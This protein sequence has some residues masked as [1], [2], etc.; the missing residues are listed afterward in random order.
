MAAMMS[1]KGSRPLM[2]YASGTSYRLSYRHAS[3]MMSENYMNSVRVKRP[4]LDI[5][6]G[7]YTIICI[8]HDHMFPLCDSVGFATS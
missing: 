5:S 4:R 2:R 6:A 7:T 3:V 8:I 1:A